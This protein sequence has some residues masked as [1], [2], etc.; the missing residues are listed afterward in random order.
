[1]DAVCQGIGNGARYFEV[2]KIDIMSWDAAIQA[3]IQRA[4][5][6]QPC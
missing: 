6:G 2:Y 5:S 4:R 1:M 3:A